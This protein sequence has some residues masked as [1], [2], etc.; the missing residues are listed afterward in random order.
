MYDILLSPQTSATINLLFTYLFTALM[1]L[2]LHRNF[3][4]FVQSRQAF[5]LPLLHSIS[6]RTVLVTNVPSHLRGDR[7]L[8]DYFEGCGWQVESVSVC[9]GIE[10][11]RR[12]LERRTNALLRL[13]A[14]WAEWVG[15]PA[16]G[17]R[18][19]DPNVYAEKNKIARSLTASPKRASEPL[20]AGIEGESSTST[21]TPTRTS[22][23]EQSTDSLSPP[24]SDT[25]GLEADTEAGEQSYAHVHMT[26]PRPVFR[27]RWFGS[28]VDAIQFWER[29][30]RKADE[31]VRDMRKTGRFDATHVAFVTFEDVKD[32]VSISHRCG[33]L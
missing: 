27:P 12:V 8:A 11:L 32:A 14:A 22:N 6:T 31:E 10:P 1:L 15:N 2:F 30:F 33:F 13:E 26:K 24:D 5:S 3:H 29:K 21:T 28:K 7:A 17:V 9:R 18:G 16:K 20:I 23:R 4:R 19:Y 25:N